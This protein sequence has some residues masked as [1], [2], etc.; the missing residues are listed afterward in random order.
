[1]YNKN[2]YKKMVDYYL[3]LGNIKK[4]TE[5]FIFTDGFSFSC[6]STFIKGLQVYGS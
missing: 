5:I 6:G 4:P 2:D 1:M 3:S